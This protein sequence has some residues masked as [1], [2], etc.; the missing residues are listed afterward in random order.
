[1]SKVTVKKEFMDELSQL[2]LENK[3]PET[4]KIEPI[5]KIKIKELLSQNP[6]LAGM[7]KKSISKKKPIELRIYKATGYRYEKIKH[8]THIGQV[9]FPPNTWN[10]SP[11]TLNLKLELNIRNILND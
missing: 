5:K 7:N 1:M 10:A 11:D 6:K 8:S 2:E 4:V 9:W 3:D